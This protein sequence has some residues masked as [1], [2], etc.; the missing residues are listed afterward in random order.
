M[1][2]RAAAIAL[3]VVLV[4]T[5]VSADLAVMRNGQALKVE[6]WRIV[7]ESV[8]LRL[9]DGGEVITSFEVL[10]AV[11][12]DEIGEPRAIDESA[13]LDLPRMILE[14]ARRGGLDPALVAAVVRVES[15]FLPEAVSPKGALGLMQLMPATAA[16]LGVT[17]PFAPDQNLAAGVRHLSGLLSRYDGDVR[18]ALAAYN[19]GAA[20]VD[21][22]GGIPPYPETRAYVE[23]VL[24]VYFA[25]K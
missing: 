11:V 4:A 15:A 1:R 24:E 3:T 7:G 18:R 8:H 19:A 21:R 12:P 10:A 20:S 13:P 6:S 25:S 9:P 2:P 23:R 17:D 16:E 5:D 14:A 22:H